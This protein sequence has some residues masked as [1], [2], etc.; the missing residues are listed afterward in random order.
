MPVTTRTLFT[1]SELV[2]LRCCDDPREVPIGKNYETE[3]GKRLRKQR[4]HRFKGKRI[5]PG[6]M[7]NL[8]YSSDRDKKIENA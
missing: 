8:R 3:A 7:K 1:L 2:E 5:K 4:P 6:G